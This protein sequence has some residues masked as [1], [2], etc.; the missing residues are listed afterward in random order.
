[1][2]Y[3][4]TMLDQ[5]RAKLDA[6]Q[7]A[8]AWELTT[9]IAK[10]EPENVRA[11]DL[12]ADIIAPVSPERASRYRQKAR[13]AESA[14]HVSAPPP[15]P[16]AAQPQ[17]SPPIM[18]YQ[19]SPAKLQLGQDIAQAE[20]DL[21]LHQNNLRTLERQLVSARGSRSGGAVVFF[22]GLFCLLFFFG[23]WPL[24]L[25]M[26]IAGTMA[27]ASAGT[28]LAAIEQDILGAEAAITDIQQ[29]LAR[30]RMQF[31]MMP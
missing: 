8:A 25:I 17:Q 27:A 15:Q 20:G 6:G 31:S 21:A 12:L 4:D 24:W 28:R 7:T 3:T 9:A 30:L 11:W 26:V 13:A 19:P 18:P 10:A 22:V 23:L 16:G 14:R 2:G 5:A 1:M 29:Q